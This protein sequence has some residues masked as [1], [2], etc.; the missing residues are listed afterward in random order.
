[1]EAEGRAGC[2][3]RAAAEQAIRALAR[4]AEGPFSGFAP[5]LLTAPTRPAVTEGDAK[6]LSRT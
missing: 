4:A 6:A 5:Y 3:Y 1:M 2:K